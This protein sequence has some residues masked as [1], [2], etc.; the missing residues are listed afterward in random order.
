[1][2]DD[3]EEV[4]NSCVDSMLTRS[5]QSQKQAADPIEKDSE[6]SMERIKFFDNQESQKHSKHT[7]YDS[8]GHR[9]NLLSP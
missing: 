9:G 5:E 2:V 3:Q 4:V 6:V 7:S 1:M 8:K